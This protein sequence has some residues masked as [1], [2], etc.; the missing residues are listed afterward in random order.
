MGRAAA[1][2]S[3]AL[4]QTVSQWR[5]SQKET[6]M[7]PRDRTT[8]TTTT[9]HA[10]STGEWLDAHFAMARPEYEAMLRSVGIR[11]GW[12]VL[13]AGCGHG[14]FL[15]WLAELVG[16]TGRITALDLAPENVAAVEARFP[17][18]ALP[19]P[20][21]AY[22]GSVL[23]LPF[24]NDVFDAAW[25]AN[26]SQYLTDAE[27]L[28]ALAEFR[29]VA[30]PGGV[31]AVKENDATLMRAYARNPYLLP[32]LWEQIIGMKASTNTNRAGGG[33]RSWLMRAGLE[34]IWLRTT[35]TERGAPYGP[36]ERAFLT[37]AFGSFSRMAPR[38]DLSPSEQA[39]WA[40]IAEHGDE[41]FSNP[42]HYFREG[43]LLAVGRVPA[44]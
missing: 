18:G 6:R 11:P 34:D 37:A 31:V 17:D 14:A 27:L 32:H 24:P 39:E 8:T 33:L 25:C 30:L 22:V 9:G 3:L 15:P 43:N 4:F 5:I 10:N 38:F 12:H 7:A 21:E 28:T 16:P 20:I 44:A 26:T 23:D 42:D 35:L 1:G 19:C 29:R 2:R 36:T 13:D 41:A 40:E